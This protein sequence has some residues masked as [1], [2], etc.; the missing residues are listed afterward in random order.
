MRP[1]GAKAWS[2]IRTSGLSSVRPVEILRALW[3]E[4]DCEVK[5]LVMPCD[6]AIPGVT[7]GR[8]VE[9]PGRVTA[10]GAVGQNVELPIELEELLEQLSLV[11]RLYAEAAATGSRNVLREALEIDPALTGID[12][13]YAESLVADMLEN[14]KEKYPRFFKE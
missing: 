6:G 5:S 4:G 1:Q 10:Q 13:L 7:E 14:Q 8:C 9:G 11:N 2:Q 12:L 3:G